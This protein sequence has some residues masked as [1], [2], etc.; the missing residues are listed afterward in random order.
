MVNILFVCSGDTCRSPII[1]AVFNE[2]IKRINKSKV[3]VSSSAGLFVNAN[4]TDISE[5]AKFALREYNIL[6]F[7]HTPTQLNEDLVKKSDLVICVNNS[8]KNSILAKMSDAKNVKSISDYIAGVE[9]SDPF[10]K[11]RAVY[12]KLCSDVRVLVVKLLDVLCK[13]GVILWLLQ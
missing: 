1:S 11:G 12:L 2:E 5:D 4:D 10:G 6:N 3:V 13:E 8:I 9:I 7:P